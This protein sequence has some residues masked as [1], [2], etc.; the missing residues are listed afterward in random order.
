MYSGR[1][2]APKLVFNGL[3]L[4]LHAPAGSGTLVDLDLRA[5]AVA[6]GLHGGEA[7]RDH[8]HYLIPFSFE[9][10]AHRRQ[11]VGQARLVDDVEGAGNEG[12]EAFSLSERRHGEFEQYHL[13]LLV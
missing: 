1:Q 8:F 5:D 6:V 10:R 13:V 3:N 2:F 9:N 4:G 7:V 11:L 12:A